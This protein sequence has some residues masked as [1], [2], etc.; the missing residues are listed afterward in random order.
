MCAVQ[1]ERWVALVRLCHLQYHVL[2]LLVHGQIGQAG[3]A[4]DFEPSPGGM[5]DH[6]VVIVRG[7]AGRA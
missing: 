1:N 7:N 3:V 6:G 5:T 2:T 4:K